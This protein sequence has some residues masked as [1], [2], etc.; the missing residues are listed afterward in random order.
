[1]LCYP[2]SILSITDKVHR[3]PKWREGN[4]SPRVLK[5]AGMDSLA[6]AWAKH[7]IQAIWDAA[8][9]S[10]AAAGIEGLL[11]LEIV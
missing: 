10:A 2:T 4:I 9:G 5:C 1:M 7:L 3:F 6:P 11:A 8:E